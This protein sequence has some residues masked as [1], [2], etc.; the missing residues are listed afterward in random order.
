[1]GVPD[2]VSC[3]QSPPAKSARQLLQSLLDVT[4]LSQ[5]STSSFPDSQPAFPG[6]Q[7]A[8]PDGQH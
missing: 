7:P 2:R 8:F 6:G 4:G 3:L 5:S 1:M